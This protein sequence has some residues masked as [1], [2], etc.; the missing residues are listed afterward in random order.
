MSR[1]NS[2]CPTSPIREI[3]EPSC[4]NSE[5]E[6][7][8]V[9]GSGERARVASEFQIRGFSHDLIQVVH[10]H[11]CNSG[12]VVYPAHDGGVVTRSEVCDD[13]GFP[14]V[15]RSMAAVLNVL[16]LVLGDFAADYR[17]LPVVV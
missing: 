8:A 16:D 5:T 7:K 11:E 9:T 12:G 1:Q 13:R 6:G 15:P 3:R 4:G 14:R 17:M 10:F 2:S